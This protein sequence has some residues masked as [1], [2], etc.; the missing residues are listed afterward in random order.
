MSLNCRSSWAANRQVHKFWSLPH[1]HYV[2]YMRCGIQRYVARHVWCLTHLHVLSLGQVH[3]LKFKFSDSVGLT[4]RFELWLRVWGVCAVF[5]FW[6]FLFLF[7]VFVDA[8]CVAFFAYF[9]CTF[10]AKLNYINWVICGIWRAVTW[11]GHNSGTWAGVVAAVVV[12]GFIVAVVVAFVERQKLWQ[13]NLTNWCGAQSSWL[14]PTSQP[15]VRSCSH[16]NGLTDSRPAV[17]TDRRRQA[18]TDGQ[19]QSTT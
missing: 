10:R 2:I 17:G 11:P 4:W 9:C 5:V 8:D 1:G 16:L 7:F 13:L 14:F 15:A 18:E 3:K 19:P 12:V 6:V